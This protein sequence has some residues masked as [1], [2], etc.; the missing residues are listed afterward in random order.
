MA[1]DR[2]CSPF[3]PGPWD[4]KE[5]RWDGRKFVADRVRSSLRIPINFPAVMRRGVALI[6]PAGA[7]MASVSGAFLS[8]V[9]EGPSRNMGRWVRVMTDPVRSEDKEFLKLDTTCPKCAR[10][11]GKNCA[12]LLAQV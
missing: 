8:R 3:D 9:F 1:T 12:V 4:G 10:A 6:E 7:R 2:C 5:I 11:F